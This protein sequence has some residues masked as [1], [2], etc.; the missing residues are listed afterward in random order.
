[1][2]I[3]RTSQL[4]H[5]TKLIYLIEVKQGRRKGW[6]TGNYTD[7]V[8]KHSEHAYQFGDMQDALKWAGHW[9]KE[10]AG[11]ISDIRIYE[12]KPVY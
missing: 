8:T 3:K 11:R 9:A 5:G 12:S 2:A 4:D 7:D 6:L 1:M 10:Q